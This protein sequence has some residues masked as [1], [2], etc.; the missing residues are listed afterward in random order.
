MFVGTTVSSTALS[1]PGAGTVYLRMAS[2]ERPHLHCAWSRGVGGTSQGVLQK[3]VV[4][5]RVPRGPEHLTPC[6]APLRMPAALWPRGRQ[7][8]G[9]CQ[10][11]RA[12]SVPSGLGKA[13][14]CLW[15]SWLG[16]RMSRPRP[17]SP[18]ALLLSLGLSHR[19]SRNS[20]GLSRRPRPSP[21]HDS[22]GSDALPRPLAAAPPLFWF[23]CPRRREEPVSWHPRGSP[24]L[25]LP[26]PGQALLLSQGGALSSQP[27]RFC[28]PVWGHLPAFPSSVA[29][30]QGF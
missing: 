14:G 23:G 26:Q 9:S 6:R 29:S 20:V 21:R 11:S 25:R 7:Q 10:Q 8:M 19:L 17:P 15:R 16:L 1:V 28:L 12:P 27:T 4:R 30:C 5:P 22:L 3:C 24:H 2:L 13:V 18:R